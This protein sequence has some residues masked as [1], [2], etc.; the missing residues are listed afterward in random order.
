MFYVCHKKSPLFL[1]GVG[2]LL[3]TVR[4]VLYAVAVFR[5]FAHIADG[6][7]RCY[8]CLPFQMS[9]SAPCCSRCAQVSAA[10]AQCQRRSANFERKSGLRYDLEPLEAIARIIPSFSSKLRIGLKSSSKI[11][12]VYL[13]TCATM[14]SP[15]R[16]T[17]GGWMMGFLTFFMVLVGRAPAGKARGGTGGRPKWL[18][19]FVRFWQFGPGDRC[20]HP[21]IRMR[22]RSTCELV[23]LPDA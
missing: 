5:R 7:R 19:G 12:N 3:A 4:A 23:E 17:S 22:K 6:G 16:M 18:V 14:P 11:S 2:C 8:G 10:R 20:C 15:S 1:R 21:V 9:C 13:V